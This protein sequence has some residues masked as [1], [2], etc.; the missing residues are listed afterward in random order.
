MHSHIKVG[1]GVDLTIREL[2]EVI[3]LVIGFSGRIDFD[4]TKPAETPRKLMYVSRLL[5]LGWH[6]KSNL[7]NGL[8]AAYQV[9][10]NQVCHIQY[11]TTT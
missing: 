6:A 9:Y 3:S 4:S 10:V 11:C 8:T 7:E 2:A 1:S 5:A